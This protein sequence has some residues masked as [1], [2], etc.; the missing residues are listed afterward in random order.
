MVVRKTGLLLALVCVVWSADKYP[1]IEYTGG[2]DYNFLKVVRSHT[3]P[4]LEKFDTLYFHDAW[5]QYFGGNVGIRALL[6]PH[7]SLN[8]C[9]TAGIWHP[10]QNVRSGYTYATY[11]RHVSRDIPTIDAVYRFGDPDKP[12]TPLEITAGYFGYSYESD[13]KSLGLYLLNCE[14]YPG[15]VYPAGERKVF[16][17]RLHSELPAIM[18]HDLLAYADP[19]SSDHDVSF[20][21][22][23]T[24][25]PIPLVNVSAGVALHRLLK[26]DPDLTNKTTYNADSYSKEENERIDAE[27]PVRSLGDTIFYS[28][29]GTKVMARAAFDPWPLIR[30]LPFFSEGDLKV[31]TE[32]AILGIKN[33]PSTPYETPAKGYPDI[34][35]RI[36]VMAGLNIPTHP[37]IGNGLVPLG[38]ALFCIGI[39][40]DSAWL[41]VQNDSV[42][43][44]SDHWVGGQHFIDTV[45]YTTEIAHAEQRGLS[46]KPWRA[47]AWSA[48]SVAT[49]MTTFLLERTLGRKLRMDNVS[50]EVE[51]YDT[52]FRN[53]GGSDYALPAVHRVPERADE[54]NW[55][56][57][58][59]FAKSFGEHVTFGGKIACD[60][61]KLKNEIGWYL[62]DEIV[63]RQGE[64]YWSAGLNI[65]F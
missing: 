60:H 14:A 46:Y 27:L 29:A 26:D 51:Y 1:R 50:V 15:I 10:Y 53:Y 18:S 43:S 19:Y 45:W 21:Y 11:G 16:G 40:P 13:A 20:A 36:P 25:K 17:L 4:A 59:C 44:I 3:P 37:I 56:W 32:A 8:L 28:K 49:G 52:P 64:W 54:D 48:A 23:A 7:L 41:E 31:Y 24:C 5:V 22:I 35:R 39:E 47:V 55:R 6:N 33:Y 58:V 42:E 12:N 9:V 65:A 61:L 57:A 63:E 34:H 62:P 30:N 38:L 2:L